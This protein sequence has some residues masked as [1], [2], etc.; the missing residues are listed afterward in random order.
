MSKEGDDDDVKM[1]DEENEAQVPI[2]YL[3][4]RYWRS[5]QMR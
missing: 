4:L 3:F 2:L 5:G 1:S